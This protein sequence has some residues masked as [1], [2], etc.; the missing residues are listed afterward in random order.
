MLF[1]FKHEKNTEKH[2]HIYLPFL[3]YKF[4]H[5]E[6][7]VSHGS[8]GLGHQLMHRL[9]PLKKAL[10]LFICNHKSFRI[11]LCIGSDI[12]SFDQ[13]TLENLQF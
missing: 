1:F 12:L 8:V 4:I 5:N 10:K 2:A 13:Q 11:P 9:V 6:V 3:T 7:R